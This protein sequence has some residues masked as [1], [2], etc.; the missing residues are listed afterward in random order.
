VW[1]VPPAGNVLDFSSY[2]AKARGFVVAS[3]PG[4]SRDGRTALMCF[5]IGPSGHGAAGHLTR[6]Y[7][8]TGAQLST[9]LS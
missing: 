2:L 9:N 7:D 6:I 5:V 4:Y 1:H 8:S 3:L